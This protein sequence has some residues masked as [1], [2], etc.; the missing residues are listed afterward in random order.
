MITAIE[1]AIVD[2]LS[3]GLGRVVWTV[4]SYGGDLEVMQ[5]SD[6]N[7]HGYIDDDV[8]NLAL[9]DATAEING[10]L[11]RYKVPFTVVPPLLTR[12]ACDI[13][14]YRLSR[15]GGH[16]GTEDIDRRYKIDVLDTLKAIARG[17]ISLG[18]DDG[19]NVVG[20]DNTV[21]FLNQNNRV[22]GR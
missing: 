21:M 7:N 22:F 16:L 11:A 2:R 13:A 14:R 1:Q 5:L 18:G 4:K 10:Y 8:V 12:L 17:V 20:N 15:V 3:K 6:R 19:N 9:D